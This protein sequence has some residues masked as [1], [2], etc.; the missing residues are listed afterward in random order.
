MEVQSLS[1]VHP[2]A[3]VT[4]ASS[5]IGLE[6]ARELCARG[7]DV[8]MVSNEEERL[9][10]CAG[11]L[12]RTYEVQTWPLYMDLSLPDAAEHLHGF[13]VAVGLQVEVLVNNDGIF[14]YD[15]VVNLSVGVVRTMLMLH[16]NTVVLL[17]RYFGEDMR[18]RG[19]GYILNMSSMSA[20]FSYPDISL[21]A[22]TKCF[23]KSFSRAFRLEML[24]YGVNVT[25]VCPGAVTT[26][27]YKLPLHLQRLAVRI[28][29]MMK[30]ETLAHRAINGM[31]RRRAQM[32]PGVINYFFIGFMLLWPYGLVRW[33]MKKVKKAI[34]NERIH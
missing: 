16:V 22:S 3:I 25:T 32:I 17:C 13:C 18:R 27:L 10:R 31:F 9:T 7:Y 6:Y 19:K 23:L 12:S 20:W 26:N 1:S 2:V 28:G 21:Y 29:V 33:T 30:P 4:G 8:V 11:E 14:R 34:G 5:G 15:H 24:D